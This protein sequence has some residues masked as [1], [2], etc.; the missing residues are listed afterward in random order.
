MPTKKIIQRH[1]PCAAVMLLV[2]RMESNPEEFRLDTGKWANL[3]AHIKKRVV[4]KN[5]D[6]FIILDDFEAEMVWNKFKAAGKKELHTFVMEKIL[7]G[8]DKK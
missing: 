1:H 7:E 5:A 4:D 8:D 3:L 2:Q 6:A